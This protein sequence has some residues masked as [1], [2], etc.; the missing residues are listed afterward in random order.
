M[1][2][3]PRLSRALHDLRGRLGPGRRRRS[4]AGCVGNAQTGPRRLC[5]RHGRGLRARPADGFTRPGTGSAGAVARR[6]VRRTETGPAAGLP[7]HVRP[8]RR[9]ADRPG[10]RHR[11]LLRLDLDHGGRARRS[12]RSPGR[13]TGLRRLALADVPAR[14]P[15]GLAARG[16]GRRTDRG[17]GGGAGHRRFGADRGGRRAGPPH[18]RL[19]GA[20][21]ERCDVRRHRLCGGARCRLLRSGADR[22]PAAHPWAPRDRGRSQS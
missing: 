17:G 2:R 13:R 18:L 12:G 20:V 15:A 14:A 21:P 8:R 5:D 19:P 4:V 16:A 1:D 7:Q 9:A 6:P 10:R 22:R 11:L 3:R